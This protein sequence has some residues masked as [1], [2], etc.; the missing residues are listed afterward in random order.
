M[1]QEI[2]RWCRTYGRWAGLLGALNLFIWTAFECLHGRG[3]AG[4]SL[5]SVRTGLAGVL[6]LFDNLLV[7]WWYADRTAAQVAL[8][9]CVRR[10]ANK[11]IVVTVRRDNADRTGYFH[12]YVQNIGPGVAVSVWWVDQEGPAGERRMRALGAL[13]P[14]DARPLGSLEGTLFGGRVNPGHLLAAEGL[15]TRTAPWTV[16][17]NHLASDGT[18]EIIPSLVP[19]AHPELARSVMELVD[20][21]WEATLKPALDAVTK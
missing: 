21:E 5:W 9:Q 15:S 3:V 2:R 7:L 11:P 16:T 1:K 10:E 13:G 12:Y 8:A 20:G 4:T 18:Y 14:G 17:V 19:L 6:L